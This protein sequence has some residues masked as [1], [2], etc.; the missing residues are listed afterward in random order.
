M[1]GGT[2]CGLSDKTECTCLVQACVCSKWG[3]GGSTVG[4]GGGGA[5]QSYVKVS[6]T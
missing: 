5:R 6:L 1:G 4:R 2:I 3:E